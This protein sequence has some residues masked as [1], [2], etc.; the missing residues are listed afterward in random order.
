MVMVCGSVFGEGSGVRLWNGGIA[1][2]VVGCGCL[3]WL[4]F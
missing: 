1:Q 4:E 2:N 3:S